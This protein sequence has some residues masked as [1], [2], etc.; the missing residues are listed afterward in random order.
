[1]FLFDPAET[2]LESFA[3][4]LEPGGTFRGG[5]LFYLKGL[6]AVYEGS[7]Q[8]SKAQVIEELQKRIGPWLETDDEIVFQ[9]LAEFTSPEANPRPPLRELG[10]IRRY[11]ARMAV[12]STVREAIPQLWHI[13]HPDRKVRL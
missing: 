9:Y 4:S 7:Y 2:T 8:S 5:L 12:Y 6:G 1:M 11:R 3:D 10:S 13:F